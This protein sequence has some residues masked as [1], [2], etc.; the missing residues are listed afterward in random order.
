MERTRLCIVG[1]LALLNPCEIHAESVGANADI[2]DK[3][4]ADEAAWLAANE[5]LFLLLGESHG[6]NEAPQV[7]RSIVCNALEVD[8]TR[9]IVVALERQVEFNPN[10]EHFLASDQNDGDKDEFL[11]A[12]SIIIGHSVP[13]WAGNDGR[14]SQAMLQLV[15]DLAAL[16]RNDPRLSVRYFDEIPK[17]L[18]PEERR[19][20]IDDGINQLKTAISQSAREYYMA[21]N[22]HEIALTSGASK[23]IVLTGNL[24]ARKAS[25]RIG[26]ID[27]LPPSKLLSESDVYSVLLSPAAGRTWHCLSAVDC[28][29][30]AIRDRARPLPEGKITGDLYLLN[31]GF[32][33][34][35]DLGVV[36][37][38]PLSS[39]NDMGKATSLLLGCN[40]QNWGCSWLIAAALYSS[41]Y[42]I[43]RASERLL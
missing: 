18:E 39:I 9:K 6:S 2:C 33:A 42:D 41:V 3:E 15:F 30:K 20:P 37:A 28:G 12:K 8:Q 16:S 14:S 4:F 35:L 17:C 27:V 21:S 24:H 13:D 40:G 26:G 43:M 34:V 31:D 36:T 38:S 25:A 32:D 22:I 11:S 5:K 29:D 7:V 19:L 23:V 1:A 10:L